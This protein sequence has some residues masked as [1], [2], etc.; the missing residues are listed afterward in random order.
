M[1]KQCPTDQEK[2]KRKECGSK[3]AA[4]ISQI[5]GQVSFPSRESG[6]LCA[7]VES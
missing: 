7:K 4:I 1:R 3:E 6:D 5:K 2:G